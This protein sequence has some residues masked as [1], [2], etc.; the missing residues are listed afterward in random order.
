MDEIK[1]EAGMKENAKFK[2]KIYNFDDPEE[3]YWIEVRCNKASISGNDKDAFMQFTKVSLEWQDE[4][5]P[6]SE[7][8]Y[9]KLVDL[10]MLIPEPPSVEELRKCMGFEEEDDAPEAEDDDT[11]DEIEDDLSDDDDG[12]PMGK[13]AEDNAKKQKAS[14]K[15]AETAKPVTEPEPEVIEEAVE[16]DE[17]AEE[18]EIEGEEA[19]DNGFD[20]DDFDF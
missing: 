7:K 12:I 19:N 10:D 18:P 11:S 13:I 16:E 5:E 1:A 8:V 14:A 2:D 9:D 4:T 17:D 20:D 15:K 3:G 6:L